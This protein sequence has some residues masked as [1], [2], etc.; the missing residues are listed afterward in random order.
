M[1]CDILARL[2]PSEK[3]VLWYRFGLDAQ[4][5]RTLAEV[6]QRLGMVREWVRQ[7]EKRAL[8]RLRRIIQA[9]ERLLSQPT[10][11]P[12]RRRR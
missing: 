4:G 11:H 5:E 3:E 1:L 12:P 9:R 10:S 6:G 7:T 8:D 2:S